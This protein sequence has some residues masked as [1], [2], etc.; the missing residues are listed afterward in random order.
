MN[1]SIVSKDHLLTGKVKNISG[2]ET[3]LDQYQGKTVLA[4]NTASKCGFTP[5]YKDLEAIYQKYKEKGLVILGF[6]SNDFGGQEPGSN[7]EVQ[8][9]CEINYGVTFPL[10]AKSSVKQGGDNELFQKLIQV[11]GQKPAWNFTKYLIEEDGKKVTHFGSADMEALQKT[12]SEV[13]D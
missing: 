12:L 7:E 2:Q 4:V 11:T 9:F 3:H 6:P 8:E 13:L 1:A 10:F 5:Q